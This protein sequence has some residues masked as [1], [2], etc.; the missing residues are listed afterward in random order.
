MKAPR[1]ARK[2]LDLSQLPDIA[3]APNDI[4]WWG[5]LSFIVIEGFTLV[6][7]AA[8]YLYLTENVQSWPPPGTLRPSLVAPTLNMLLMLASLVLV[9]QVQRAAR[10]FELSRVK[11]GLAFL[12]LL[13]VVFVGLRCWELLRSLNVRWDTNAYGSAQWLVL[14]LHG[15][16][17]L[18]ELVEIGGMALMFWVGKA[19]EKHFSDVYDICFY[20]QFMVLAWVPLYLMC[21]WLPRWI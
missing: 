4:M 20:W 18:I 15:T 7:A 8:A 16:L 14:V 17:L 6:L 19:E 2:V 21:F 11:A 3:F 10:H 9:G 12:T 13:N 5:T 1:P